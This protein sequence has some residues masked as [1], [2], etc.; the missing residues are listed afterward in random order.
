M[1]MQKW[2]LTAVIAMLMLSFTVGQPQV[3]AASLKEMKEEKQSLEEKKKSLNANIEK[4]EGEIS[5][6]KSQIETTQDKITKLNG[7]VEATSQQIKETQQV[8]DETIAE[9]ESLKA[10]IED[11]ERKIAE[12][13]EVLRDRVRAMQANGGKVSY[14]DVLLGANSFADFIDRISAVNTL[15]DADRQIMEDQANDQKRLEEEKKLVEKKL[16][17]LQQEK[18]KLETLKASLESKKAEQNR[19][20]EQLKVEQEELQ[21]EKGE[22]ETDLHEA[23]EFSAALDKEIQAE[24]GRLAELARQ[25]ELERKRQAEAQAQANGGS[26]SGG[27]SASGGGSAP[28]VSSGTWTRPASGRISSEFGGRNLSWASSNHRGIDVANGIGTP[29]VAAGDGVVS[30]TGTLG[31]YGNIV[32]ITHSVNGKIY[33]TLYAHLSSSSVSVGQSVA[34]GQSIGRMGNTGRVSG[35]HLHFEF[36]VGGWTGYGPSAV[37]PRSY[38]PF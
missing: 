37:N 34:K 8:I 25:A 36:H 17:E 30:R 33:T 19:L 10:S 7:E 18:E 3:L 23:Y 22:L 38:V 11:L 1:R 2:L 29:I 35:P 13:D 16:E 5:T 28:S 14:I 32:M 27:S 31:T 9:V 15:V 6:N 21:A 12:R 4:K 26:T 20:V 24:E